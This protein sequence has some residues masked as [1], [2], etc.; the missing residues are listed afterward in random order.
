MKVRSGVESGGDGLGDEGIG[1]VV[2]YLGAIAQG[3]TIGV[4]RLGIGAEL[5]F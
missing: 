1:A 5:K 3:V 4:G 2:I